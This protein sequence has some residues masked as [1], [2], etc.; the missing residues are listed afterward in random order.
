MGV[1]FSEII[2]VTQQLKPVPGRLEPM[3]IASDITVVIDYAHTP[4][5]LYRAITA[6][7][8]TQQGCIWVVFGCGG[9][10]DRGKRS[11]MGAVAAR[12]A[13]RIVVTSDNPRGEPPEAIIQDILAG[14]GDVTPLVE[15]DRATAISLVITK[16]AA[17]DTVLIAGKGHE[18]YQEIAGA[19]IPFSDV[20][21]ANHY[22]A[23]RR[24][25]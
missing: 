18:T 13:D 4:D 23:Q 21:C 1:P 11:E 24:A 3:D 10:R 14:C 9:D 2:A 15:V 25:A 19:R 22:L 5:A 20:Q 7:S 12:L 16:A 8:E 6:I 17:G